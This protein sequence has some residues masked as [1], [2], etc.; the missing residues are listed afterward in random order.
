ML[1]QIILYRM[2]GTPP[3]VVGPCI[4]W[5]FGPNRTRRVRSIKNPRS[6]AGT[7]PAYAGWKDAHAATP[8][9]T[10]AEEKILHRHLSAMALNYGLR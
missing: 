6:K 7:A 1:S 5:A 2:P 3:S 8:L 4:F 10:D 9:K